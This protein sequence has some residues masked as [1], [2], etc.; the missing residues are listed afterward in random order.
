MKKILFHLGKYS[1]W[2]PHVKKNHSQHKFDLQAL[3]P[4]TQTPQICATS[5]SEMGSEIMNLFCNQRDFYSEYLSKD[6]KQRVK[7]QSKL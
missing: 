4:M 5:S 7:K 3:F 1:V 6:P 2:F